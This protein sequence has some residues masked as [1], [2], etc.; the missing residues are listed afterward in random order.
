VFDPACASDVAAQMASA[1]V[2]LLENHGVLIIAESLELGLWRA[3]A[4]ERRCRMAWRVEAMGGGRPMAPE[5]VSLNRRILLESFRGLFPGY[6]E[7]M[8]RRELRFD[9]S[10][11][12]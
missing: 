9:A 6:L 7:Y 1:E 5:A 11:L 2:A 10:V 3:Y 8:V 4:L 12:D